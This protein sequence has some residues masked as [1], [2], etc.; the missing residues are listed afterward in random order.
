MALGKTESDPVPCAD[1]RNIVPIHGETGLAA[2]ENARSAERQNY[3][4]PTHGK[5]TITEQK[6]VRSAEPQ[7]RLLRTRIHGQ[8][9]PVRYAAILAAIPIRQQYGIPDIRRQ[10]RGIS[11]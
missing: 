8:T 2:Q 4:P 11:I 9:E 1:I 3:V 5:I 7:H 10:Q 6:H